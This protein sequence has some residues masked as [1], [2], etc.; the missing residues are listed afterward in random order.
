MAAQPKESL[1]LNATTPLKVGTETKFEDVDVEG[2]PTLK[3]RGGMDQPAGLMS[4]MICASVF[5]VLVNGAV[6]GILIWQSTKLDD[7]NC[8][9]SLVDIVLA[10]GIFNIA[11]GVFTMGTIMAVFFTETK[12][13]DACCGCLLLLT[14]FGNLGCL[15]GTTAM[16]WG[17]EANDCPDDTLGDLRTTIIVIWCLM[18]VDCILNGRKNM[19]AGQQQV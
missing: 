19:N 15:I 6:G 1:D 11:S 16:A 3:L 8:H 5:T 12:M 18:A 7:A 13:D 10:Y 17:G 9:T 14:A 4:L 2:Q